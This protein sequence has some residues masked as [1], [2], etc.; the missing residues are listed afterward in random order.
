[1]AGGLVDGIEFAE[2]G[3][4]VGVGVG[5]GVEGVSGTWF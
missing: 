1:V 5:V 4:G 2:F 3:L